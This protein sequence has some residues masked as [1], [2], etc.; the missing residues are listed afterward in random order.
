MLGLG[1]WEERM[2][3]STSNSD[4]FIVAGDDDDAC[5]EKTGASVDDKGTGTTEDGEESRDN[6]ARLGLSLM[7]S[8]D[9]SS[10]NC[11]RLS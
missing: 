5:D 10:R 1:I 6:L 8:D 7:F 11:V 9:F 3:T 4:D 2:I